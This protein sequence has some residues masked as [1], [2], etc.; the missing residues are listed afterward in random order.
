MQDTCYVGDAAG[1]KS[2]NGRP[3]DHSDCDLK[4]ARNAG[5]RFMLPEV[6]GALAVADGKEFFLGKTNVS[7]PDPPEGFRPAQL[8]IPD[9]RAY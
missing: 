9:D 6:S 2:P 3:V 4:L 7:Y 5:I 8:H 1:R